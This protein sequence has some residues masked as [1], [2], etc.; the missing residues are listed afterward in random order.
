MDLALLM[1]LRISEFELDREKLSKRRLSLA[2]TA[3]VNLRLV[4]KGSRVS[5]SFCRL[6]K[7]W[8]IRSLRSAFGDSLALLALLIQEALRCRGVPR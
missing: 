6:V 5:N 3:A 4:L 1:F 8:T 2:G 7:V